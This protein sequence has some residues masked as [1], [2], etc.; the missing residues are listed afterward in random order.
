MNHPSTL[1]R[2]RSVAPGLERLERSGWLP[3]HRHRE[4]YALIAVDG[5]FEQAS[6]GGRVTARAGDLLIQPT[7]DCHAN[8]TLGGHVR[9]LRLPWRFEAGTGGVH[10]LADLDAVVRAARRSPD[11][12]L[13][14]VERQVAAG[15]P[16]TPCV[17][18]WEDE[19]A[20]QIVAGGV[21]ELRDWARANAIAPE[22]LSRGFRRRY[23][24]TPSRFRLEWRTR[25]ACLR[26]ASRAGANALR[27]VAAETGFADQA[28]M[29]RC[30]LEM[31]GATPGQWRAR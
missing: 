20:R 17:D 12:A 27:D 25:A 24:V 6:Y 21:G 4:A 2:L 14:L 26:L 1:P 19:L 28:H 30:V 31:T 18:D 5:V 8:R 16:S 10:A 22:T 15:A 3:R 23:G 29:S 9:V 11:E 7:L 13:E